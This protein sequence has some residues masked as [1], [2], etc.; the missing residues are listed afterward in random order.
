MITGWADSA[1]YMQET[2]FVFSMLLLAPYLGW[3]LYALRMRYLFHEELPPLVEI[4]TLVALLAFFGIELLVLDR[5]LA[6]DPVVYLFT[7]LAF[8]ISGTALYG[9]VFISVVSRILVDT[10]LPNDDLNTA[11]PRF[12]PAEELERRGDFE[13]A[14]QE[15]LVIARIYPKDPAT[16]LRVANVY[17]ELKQPAESAHWFERAMVR[18]DD[19]D[20]ALSIVNRLCGF[21]DGDLGRPEDAIRTLEGFLD[22]FPKSEYSDRVRLRLVRRKQAPAPSAREEDL[23]PSPN[24]LRL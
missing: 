1:E 4:A 17:A 3:G 13:G 16:S 19:P 11:G 22:K 10:V 5:W 18:V 8:V 23:P 15:Y 20:R 9:H 14:L 6:A 12:G 24:L 21:Y 7:V 2:A